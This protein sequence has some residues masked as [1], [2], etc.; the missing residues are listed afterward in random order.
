MTADRWPSPGSAL[1]NSPDDGVRFERR[2]H[3]NTAFIGNVV[4]A[5]IDRFER[6]AIGNGQGHGRTR[7]VIDIA[8]RQGNGLERWRSFN[9]RGEMF[10]VVRF[11]LDTTQVHIQDGFGSTQCRQRCA[12]DLDLDFVLGSFM[13]HVKSLGTSL[14]LEL[15]MCSQVTSLPV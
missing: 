4:A 10:K 13:S 12:R 14:S 11:E 2:R 3:G 9:R 15:S 8:M 7:F 6:L 1:S 5:Q